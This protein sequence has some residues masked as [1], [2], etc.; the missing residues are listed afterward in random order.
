MLHLHDLY[1][2]QIS[3]GGKS[4]TRSNPADRTFVL[5][6]ALKG[7]LMPF[8]IDNPLVT[9]YDNEPTSILSYFLSTK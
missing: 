3:L 5:K 4:E 8:T 7:R 6:N 2:N 9:V 1:K